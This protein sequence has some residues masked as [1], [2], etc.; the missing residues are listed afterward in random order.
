[1]ILAVYFNG[2]VLIYNIGA[3]YRFDCGKAVNS[4]SETAE[5]IRGFFS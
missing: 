1:M 2:V 3:D 5:Q 4:G